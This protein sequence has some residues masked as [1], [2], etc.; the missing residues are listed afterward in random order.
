MEIS[1]SAAVNNAI[2]AQREGRVQEAKEIYQVIL[3]NQPKHPDANHNMG[4]IAANNNE[5]EYADN[6]F[7]TAINA[8]SEVKQYWLSYLR[9]LINFKRLEEAKS[10]YQ[11]AQ[12]K[13]VTEDPFV[14]IRIALNI[15]SEPTGNESIKPASKRFL[16]TKN[17]ASRAGVHKDTLLRWLRGKIIPEPTRDHRGWRIF[18]IEEAEAIKVY[19]KS[20]NFYPSSSNHSSQN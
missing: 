16:N 15:A 7:K 19:A 9:L 3:N 18:T 20:G 8:N 10:V 2:S 13:G 12:K 1:V 6:Y 17:V 11:K 4:V 5:F 14:K